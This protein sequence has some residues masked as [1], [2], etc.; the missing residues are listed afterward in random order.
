[1]YIHD[2]QKNPPP[3][4]LPADRPACICATL[5]RT[6]RALTAR[7]DDALAPTGL[8]LTQYSL[9][10]AV[11][12]HGTIPMSDLARVLAM[13]RSTLTRNLAPLESAG[14]LTLR[15]AASGRAK[16][17]ALSQ[18]GRTCLSNAYPIW[19]EAQQ[20]IT[21]QAGEKTVRDLVR[22]AIALESGLRHRER[23]HRG[24]TG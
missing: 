5:R 19:L 6:T 12:T 23:N 1:L 8:R 17:V 14:L 13:D 22:A 15:P 20:R 9:L 2:V 21:A 24:A 18:R 7:Y 16:L 11:D 10:A 3:R 4:V